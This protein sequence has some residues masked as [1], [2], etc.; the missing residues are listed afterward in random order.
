MVDFRVDHIALL[1]QG[2]RAE[3]TECLQRGPCLLKAQLSVPRRCHIIS[4]G[5]YDVYMMKN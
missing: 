2:G 4:N 3:S 1:R 5:E